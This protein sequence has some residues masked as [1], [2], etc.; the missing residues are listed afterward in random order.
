MK[1]IRAACLVSAMALCT[2]ANAQEANRPVQDAGDIGDIVVTATRQSTLL[3]KTPVTLSA[4]TGIGLRNAG[5]TD[6]RALTNVVPNLALT[7]SGDAVRISIRGVTSTDTTEKGDPSAAFLL[8]GVYIARPS[9]TLGSFYDIERVEVLRGPQGTLYGRNT[10]A[11]VINV[12]AKRPKDEFEASVD[13]SYGNLNSLDTTGMVNF[14][15]GNGLGIRAAVNY[16]R[17]DSFYTVAGTPAVDL[18][19]FR[20]VLSTRV[21]FGGETGNLTFVI[22]GDYTQTKGSGTV[23]NVVTL[24]RFYDPATLTPTNDPLFIG[25]SADERRLLTLSPTYPTRRDNKAYG[26]MGEFTYDAGPVQIT[27][28]GSYRKTDRN[29]V[30]N[31]MLYSAL[32][33]P[34]FYF[35]EFKQQSH[36]LRVAFG[37]G[38]PLH[39]QIGGYYFREKSVLELNLG[40][41]LSGFVAPGATGFAFPQGPTISSSKAVFGQVTYDITSAF[42]ISGG[43]RYTHDFKSRNGATVVDFPDLASS[44]CGALR[45]TLNQ[46][47]AAK[48]YGKT[49]WK[50]GLDYDIP[51]LGLAYA[52]VST[53]YK[54]GGFNDGCV[55]GSG[56]GCTLTDAAL[57]YNPETLTNYEAG[58]KFRVSNAFRFN[59][60]AFHYAY[61]SLQVSQLV[62]VPV[63]ATLISNAAKAKVD[64]FEFESTLKPSE[65]DTFELGYTYTNARYSSFFPDAANRPTFS[66]AGRQLDHA[67]KNVVTAAYTHSFPLGNGGRIE[68]GVRSRMSSEY[69]ILDLNNLSQFR[70]PAFTKTDA[71]LTYTAPSDS[72]YVQ[73]FVQNIENNITVANAVSGIA[74]GVTIEAP[75]LYGVRAGFKF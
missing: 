26:I 23:G 69:F 62:S 7:E 54:A 10:T 31:L 40:A 33:N 30:R 12:I 15:L 37:N 56:I 65:N 49:I 3:S 13:A 67:P 71:T 74:A 48:S 16:Q 53:G 63:P 70:Q 20:D 50:V 58:V 17:Q 60:A 72:Y 73:G 32:N 61:N 39:G 66:L 21:S 22:R 36:E 47:I 2:P 41:P 24:D 43:V 8:D 4:I 68:A 28:L 35:G 51:G 1:L 46:N 5:I 52:A 57:Y 59:A 45:C 29:D 19:P 38:N 34:A 42:H 44:F 27:Y 64:G 75:R 18:T 25:G 55:A 9:D 6:A 11:G 14:G